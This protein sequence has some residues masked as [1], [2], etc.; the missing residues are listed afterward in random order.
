MTASFAIAIILFALFVNFLVYKAGVVRGKAIQRQIVE[1]I[2]PI[3]PCN[4]TWGEHKD[5][6]ECQAQERREVL[7]KD[8]RFMRYEYSSCACT[9]YHG[10]IVLTEEFYHPGIATEIEQ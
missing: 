9:K 8:Y 1:K 2:K 3:C 5:G 7:G 10:P 6:G 4:H